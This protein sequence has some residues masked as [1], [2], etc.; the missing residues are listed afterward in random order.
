[1]SD[2]LGQ[3]LN[4][5]LYGSSSK[6]DN[7][8]PKKLQPN[9]FLE[10]LKDKGNN[11]NQNDK[12]NN[13]FPA[14]FSEFL[15]QRELRI[16]QQEQIMAQNQRREEQVLFHRKNEETKTQI[17]QIKAEIKQII[18]TTGELSAELLETEKTISTTIV[19]T[20]DY[21]V[22]FFQRI[23]KFIAITRKNLSESQQWLEIFNQRSKTKS[24]YWSQVKKSG[25]SF[26]LS[27]ERTV[28]TQTG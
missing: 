5:N 18:V 12:V 15:K 4:T 14:D 26:M 17:E 11:S 23:K 24:Y 27:S 21:H 13:N 3:T 10:M 20:G 16:R 1:M 8:K 2:N 25:T 9:S 22:S 19:E 7:N 6:A 28:V